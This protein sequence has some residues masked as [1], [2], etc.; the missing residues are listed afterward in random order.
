MS[1]IFQWCYYDKD[2]EQQGHSAS[3]DGYTWDKDD[4]L[5]IVRRPS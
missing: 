4:S 2:E 1:C 3:F 5:K